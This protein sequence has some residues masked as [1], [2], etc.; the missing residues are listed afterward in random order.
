MGL[1]K[2]TDILSLSNL[3]ISQAIIETEDKLNKGREKLS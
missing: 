2:F 3:E 1:P